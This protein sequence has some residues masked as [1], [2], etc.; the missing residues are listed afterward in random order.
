MSRADRKVMRYLTEAHAAEVGLLNVLRS[1]IAIAPRGPYR[2]ALQTHLRETGDH[3]LR[4]R[5]RL[6]EL[7]QRQDPARLLIGAA[8]AVVSR[9][10]A[11]AKTPVD[12][13]RGTSGEERVL[14]NAKDAYATEALE[15]ATYTA[16]ERLATDVGDEQ[17]AKLA[18]SIRGDEERMLARIARELPEL[19]AA[20]VAAEV[21]GSR[22][23]TSR[24]PA[25]P[26]RR[27]APRRTSRNARGRRKPARGGPARQ[28]R[29]V[30]G[31]ARAE[32]ELKGAV[33][34]VNDLAIPR[35]DSLTVEEIVAQLP[36]LPQIEIA[37]ID[38]YERRHDNRS[39]VLGRITA[40]RHAEPWPG[41]DEL[42]V[43]EI[44]A[45]LSERDDDQ[46]K[47]VAAYERAHKNRAGVLATAERA[48]A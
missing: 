13:I 12:V 31:V 42:T 24:R 3:A 4:L 41:Y 25:P 16:L 23:T 21:N 43:G 33:A 19:T 34:Q 5:E 35:Y 36:E 8:E 7:G 20:V 29:K 48:R 32:G 14:K 38:A 44:E 46:A 10:L 39:T 22:R 26:M 28:A 11:L 18:A 47:K 30:P 15:I 37:K 6:R 9:T 1:Q 45:V 17:T 2:D 40:L 27:G